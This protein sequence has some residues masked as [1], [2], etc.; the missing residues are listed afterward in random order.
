[1]SPINSSSSTSSSLPSDFVAC[2]LS[3]VCLLG[4]SFVFFCF[5]VFFNV[6]TGGVG[7][8]EGVARAVLDFL[9]AE[10]EAFFFCCRF[11]FVSSVTSSAGVAAAAAAAG[12]GAFCCVFNFF[13]LVGMA[14]DPESD[15][16]HAVPPV[17]GRLLSSLSL[18]FLRLLLLVLPLVR[19]PPQLPSPNDATTTLASAPS[20]NIKYSDSHGSSWISSPFG[21][22]DIMINRR[23][24]PFPDSDVEDDRFRFFAVDAGIAFEATPPPSASSCC[25]VV[26]FIFIRFP[27]TTAMCLLGP[28]LKWTA[29]GSSPDKYSEPRCC[30]FCC[31]A[32]FRPIPVCPVLLVLPPSTDNTNGSRYSSCICTEVNNSYKKS[33][34][35]ISWSRTNRRSLIF[36]PLLL[37]IPSPSFPV[38]SAVVVEVVVQSNE[39]VNRLVDAEPPIPEGTSPGDPPDII[40]ICW[41]GG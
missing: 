29:A 13:L 21:E 36:F 2:F 4:V 38:A 7:E 9:G 27:F 20:S 17:T 11:A 25:D 41:L 39:I 37:P 5:G 10:V 6:T 23:H 15:A 19:P 18:F 22:M 3:S 16:S 40:I 26:D 32:F 8:D 30:N 31:F 28:R 35:D 24:R 14:S 12:G 33:S 1:M 34:T